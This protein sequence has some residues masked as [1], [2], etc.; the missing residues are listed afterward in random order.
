MWI[1]SVG[2]RREGL[3]TMMTVLSVCG[4]PGSIGVDHSVPEVI[5]SGCVG[6]EAVV[7]ADNGGGR[8]QRLGTP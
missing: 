3:D 5:K 2:G 1:G 8:R 7:E 6:L 4:V